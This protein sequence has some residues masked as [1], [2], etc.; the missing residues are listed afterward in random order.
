ML[1][2]ARP[3]GIILWSNYN[4][5]ETLHTRQL[6]G[7]LHGLIR[8]LKL[9]TRALT[10]LP[11]EKKL[12]IIWVIIFRRL[13]GR[14]IS[15]EPDRELSVSSGRISKTFWL[16]KSGSCQELARGENCYPAPIWCSL[17]SSEWSINSEKWPATMC[18]TVQC[19]WCQV[20]IS[21]QL[22]SLCAI[23]HC[24]QG[25]KHRGLR[26]KRKYWAVIGGGMMMMAGERECRIKRV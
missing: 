20:A 5:T 9:S 13:P 24:M 15:L 3:C 1:C 17:P 10:I 12:E 25:Y 8:V 18:I 2:G 19:P 11:G 6:G 7:T 14:I 16:R 23:H 4:Y 21:D 22:P 26:R